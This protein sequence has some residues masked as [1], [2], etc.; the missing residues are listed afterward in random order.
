MRRYYNYISAVLFYFNIVYSQASGFNSNVFDKLQ[1]YDIKFYFLD[2]EVNNLSEYVE[3]NTTILF[4]LNDPGVDTIVLEL[5][6]SAQVDSVFI[7]N[8]RTEFMHSENLLY[9]PLTGTFSPA[10]AISSTIFYSV[11]MVS[12]TNKGVSTD[13]TE[14]GKSVTWT[15]S[16]PFYSRNWFPCKQILEDKADSL[17]LFFTVPDSLRVGS[18]GILTSITNLPNGKKRYEW[19]SYYPVA[20]YLISFATADYMD[21]SYYARMNNT[22]SILIQNYIYDDSSYFISNKEAI[23]AT[24]QILKVFQDRF[25]TYPFY[26][27]KYGHCVVPIG[28]GMEHQTMTTLGNFNFVLVAHEL[29]HQWFGDNVTCQ[30]W[31]DIWI[32]EGFASYCELV[33]IE[34]LK[35]D[36]EVQEWLSEAFNL[37]VSEPDGS[38]FVPKSDSTNSSRIFNYRLSY[39]KGAYI[40]HMIRHELGSDELFF[41]VLK[42]FQ[43]QYKNGVANSNDFISLL[44]DL[45]QR[46]FSEFFDQWYFGEGYPTLDFYWIQRQ[47]T[48]SVKIVQEVSAPTV[49]PFF[50]LLIDL[51]I[52]Y[53][54]GDTIVQFR[55]T[56]PESVFQIVLNKRV[57]QITPDPMNNILAEI[58]SITR[59]FEGDSASNFSAFPNPASTKIYIE[60]YNV[61]LPF[62]AKLYS[63]NG[64]MIKETTSSDAFGS[65]DISSLN[66]GLYQIVV[67]RDQ[68]KEVFKITKL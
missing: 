16:E 40:L 58:R 56:S 18:N 62:T 39:R 8:E 35:A 27:E 25:G 32:N 42:K 43:E 20:Y 13:I 59:Q 33:A 7:N 44:E 12:E 38:V 14:S 48:L 51:K 29:A 28:G 24:G 21:Y 17:Y 22:D 5:T 1:A 45:S 68:H 36:Q 26:K 19:K 57:Y 6:D 30:N 10:T 4:E 63:N 49:T 64:I 50:N 46:D 55:Q 37:I 67:F 23:D 2:L 47:D 11:I 53:M 61:G 34:N 54:G 15:L 66:P 65:F 3:G 52:S 60:N 9:I 41:E 31:Q